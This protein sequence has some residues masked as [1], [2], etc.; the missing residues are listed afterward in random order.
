[1]KAF[2]YLVILLF[3]SSCQGSQPT[4]QELYT[5]EIDTQ[6]V[7]H[8]SRECD[9]IQVR[10]LGN[11]RILIYRNGV[12]NS[13]LKIPSSSD[14]KNL[15]VSNLKESKSGIELFINWGG[16]NYLYDNVY[17]FKDSASKY[18]LTRVKSTLNK[19]HEDVYI[20]TDTLL[21]QYIVIDSVKL[22]ELLQ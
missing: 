15:K 13:L 12:Y 3:L 6:R 2:N 19:H 4:Q 21:Q 9:A 10:D 18:F 14:V 5:V 11:R 1:M 8:V 16:G 22:E 17:C 7:F 20:T